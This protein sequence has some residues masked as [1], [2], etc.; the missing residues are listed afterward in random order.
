ML[1]IAL[2]GR[3]ERKI[4]NVARAEVSKKATWSPK[5]YDVFQAIAIVQA[6]LHATEVHERIVLDRVEVDER[7]CLCWQ[8][9]S[10]WG[11]GGVEAVGVVYQ[12][13]YGGRQT[14]LITLPP[15]P[16]IGQLIANCL[17]HRVLGGRKG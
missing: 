13:G 5:T 2:I 16:G 3:D 14:F 12:I 7:L 11:D 10:E 1:V 15:P 9:R 17:A 6:G 4:R 8:S